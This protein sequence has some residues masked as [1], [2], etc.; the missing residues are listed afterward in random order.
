LTKIADRLKFNKNKSAAVKQ[1]EAIN[2]HFYINLRVQPALKKLISNQQFQSNTK[3]IC[4]N[5]LIFIIP[6][7]TD[8]K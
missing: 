6:L 7:T 4:I 8:C 3:I 1:F 5:Q 2:H